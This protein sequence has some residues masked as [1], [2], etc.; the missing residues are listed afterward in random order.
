MRD[1]GVYLHLMTNLPS[2]LYTHTQYQ[3]VVHEVFK[4]ARSLRMSV[5]T[6]A[7]LRLVGIIGVESYF[8]KRLGL[9]G[10]DEAK[11]TYAARLAAAG[12]SGYALL[13]RLADYNPVSGK[14]LSESGSITLPR[15]DRGDP[16]SRRIIIAQRCM[17]L[18]GKVVSALRQEAGWLHQVRAWCVC[19][20]K[21][22]CLCSSSHML[23]ALNRTRSW[24]RACASI[25]WR[26]IQ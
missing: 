12:S 3:D 17:G 18:R 13:A 21:R 15:S 23:H 20:A 7:L 9:A 16:P 1:A 26:L 14:P 22:D 2:L 10:F 8:Q 11:A 24:Q 25:C 4:I 5:S 19:V 6:E